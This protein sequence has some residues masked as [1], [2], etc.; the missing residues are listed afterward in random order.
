[1]KLKIL[2]VL[3]LVLTLVVTGCARIRSMIPVEGPWAA[4]F[5]ILVAVVFAA[6]YFA[7]FFLLS[8]RPV[9]LLFKR[10]FSLIRRMTKR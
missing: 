9:S 4:L 8:S 3:T 5:V 1:M 2:T 10:G 7:A 6:L